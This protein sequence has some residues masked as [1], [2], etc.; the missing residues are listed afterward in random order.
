M[1]TL[2]TRRRGVAGLAGLAGLPGLIGWARWTMATPHALGSAAGV[3]PWLAGTAPQPAVA[4]PQADDLPRP[5]RPLRFP[6]DFG[7][8]LGTRLEWWYVT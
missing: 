5:G 2:L 1:A 7:A 3:L 6:R 4:D 8:H